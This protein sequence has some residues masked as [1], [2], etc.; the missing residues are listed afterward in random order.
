MGFGKRAPGAWA[1]KSGAG[2][3]KAPR[4]S[5]VATALL[6][7]LIGLGA[8]SAATMVHASERGLLNGLFE[9]IFGGGAAT[10]VPVAKPASTPPRRY[11]ALPG[12]RFGQRTP[13]FEARPV[14]TGARERSP[15][16]AAFAA[17]TRTV[18]VRRCD[19]YVFPLGRLR[20]RA[21]LPVHA[22]AC[23]AACPN[24][25]TDLFTLAPGRSELDQAVGLDGRPYRRTASANL[26]RRTRVESCSC[27]PPG[28]A[29]QLM[30]LAADRTLRP[31]DV[32]GSEVGADFVAGLSPNGPA[33]VDYRIAALGRQRRD[34]IEDRV[35]ALRR[36]AARLAFREV[37]RAGRTEPRRLRVAEAQ[38]MQAR[39]DAAPAGFAPV[40]ARGEGFAS[41]RV[42]SPS[43]FGR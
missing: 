9:T 14:R 28:V 6:G 22:A 38:I 23:A 41:V 29:G 19:G 33:L 10:P 18:C 34:A 7:L 31:G 11:A 20:S 15:S 8:T 39:I 1:A 13:R 12:N 32:I 17:G 5:F 30:P 3:A 36:D 4:R 2:S 21:D 25:P 43:P 16:P 37:L 35:G 40:A 27:Q 26:Y 42:V 24:A